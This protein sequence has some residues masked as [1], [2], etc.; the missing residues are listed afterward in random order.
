MDF[1]IIVKPSAQIDLEE[2]ILW[3]KELTKSLMPF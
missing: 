2:A 3:W 1:D